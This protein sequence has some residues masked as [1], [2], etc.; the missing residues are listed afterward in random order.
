MG[1][2]SYTP[3]HGPS[4]EGRRGHP[5]LF[6]AVRRPVVGGALAVG[7]LGT[8]GAT[9]AIGEPA[10]LGASA[11]AFT[12]ASKAAEP[13]ADDAA[14]E[15]AARMAEDRRS[16]NV[17]RSA[18]REQ[19]RRAVAEREKKAEAKKKAKAERAE[20]LEKRKQAAAEKKAEAAEERERENDEK[21]VSER[22]FTAAELAAIRKDPKPYAIALMREK[23]WE[24]SEWSCLDSLWVGESDWE[25]DATNSSSGAYG[26]PQAL[27]GNK[28]A[29]AGSDWKT[30]PITQ[31]IWGLDYIEQSYGS[32][33][34][35]KAFWDSKDPHWY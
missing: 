26:I 10:D 17:S 6:A 32:P 34:E 11:G 4:R 8:V 2:S 5:R 7:L 25:W 27:P 29:A 14:N 3:R 16:A 13:S 22:D 9:V 18:S 24:D 23:G 19:D 35:A 33:C 30:N 28:M 15:D 20:K 12:P 31:L 21:P 1:S